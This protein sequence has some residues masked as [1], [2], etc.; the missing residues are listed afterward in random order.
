[1]LFTLIQIIADTIE[2]LEDRYRGMM[3][4]LAYRILKNH[5]S[6]ED[7]VQE[8]LLSLSQNMDKLDNLHSRR[9]QNYIYTVTQ[10]AAL[11]ALRKEKRQNCS[12]YDEDDAIENIAGQL[13]IDAFSNRY[14]FSPRVAEA[15]EQLQPLDRDILC[16]R[17]GAG[18]TPREIA[19]YLGESRDFVY[20][21]IRR[22]EAKLA[23][24]LEK[25]EEER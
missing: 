4:A 13:D 10:N 21:R 9:S 20:K 24:I 2:E 17:Y 8:A 18:Y 22:A 6:A 25:K 14:G 15:L 12:Y 16:Y 19:K 3:Q 1:M 11:S 7:A 5:H 23:D